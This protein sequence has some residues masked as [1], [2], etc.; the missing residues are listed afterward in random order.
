MNFI[1]TTPEPMWRMHV[2]TAKDQAERALAALHR[3]GVLHPEQAEALEHVERAAIERERSA[4]NS[5]LGDIEDVLAYVPQDETVRISADVEVFL[6]QPADEIA[7]RTRRVCTALAASHRRAEQLDEQATR[8]RELRHIARLLAARPGMSTRDFAFSGEHLYARLVAWRHDEFEAVRE[9]L[10]KLSFSWERLD[11]QPTT[12]EHEDED[13][14]LFAGQVVVFMVGSTRDLPALETLV[15]HHG[16]FIG[17]P[18]G[19]AAK[20][21]LPQPLDEFMLRAAK[22]LRRLD[23][24]RA[25]LRADL[26]ART[27]DELEELVLL[28]EG[29][30]AERERLGLLAMACE[31]RYITLFE[32]WVPASVVDD[33]SAQLREELDC[34]H[35]QSRPAGPDDAPPSR[36]QNPAA[37]RP[38]ELIVN[39]FSTPRY[40]EWDPTPVVAYSFALFFGIML[41]DAVYGAL[42]LLLSHYL[43][44]R[45]VDD[46]EAPG[47]LAFRRLLSICAGGAIVMGVLQ[48]AYLGNFL[49]HFFGVPE[50][51]LSRTLQD[52]YLEPMLFIIVSLGIGLLHV[53]FGHLLM[54]VRGVRERRR[55]LVLGRLALFMLQ[56]A[57]LPWIL[58]LLNIEWLE[59]HAGLG[60]TAYSVLLWLMLASVAL[61]I[62]ASVMER[63]AFL[64]GILWVFDLS[65]ILGDVMSYARLAGVGLA[66]YFLAFS[67]NMM[68]TLVAGMFPDGLVGLVLG[69]VA[70]T[71]ILVFGHLLNLLLSSITCFVHALRLCFVEFMFK[72]YEGGGRPYA[73]FRLRRRTL[74]PVKADSGAA[75]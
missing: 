41:G 30:R 67:F 20:T 2:L 18:D 42:L 31:S 35:V 8:W 6:T 63:G 19:D 40:G 66:T 29:L 9:R 54:L 49:A 14:A 26:A 75:G 32:G 53:N 45:W 21:G 57:A 15:K 60:E 25:Q 58:R 27:R 46:P 44:P 39:L 1:V 50:L 62:V 72:F 52:F 12:D 65:G 56:I 3:V 74:L 64:G 71:F 55:D 22:M 16:R 37:L 51:A 73:P 43:L 24:E 11:D 38:F 48:G 59:T 28:R 69:A 34:V 33:A 7:E 36:L 47:F 4:V 17:L 10:A 13:E 61:I 5:L 23:E 68:A 70:V